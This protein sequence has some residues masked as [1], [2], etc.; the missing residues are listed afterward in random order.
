MDSQFDCASI[1]FYLFRNC[2]ECLLKTCLKPTGTLTA[3]RLIIIL[4]W[5]IVARTVV[6][7]AVYCT[8]YTV[9][10][11][12]QYN[13]HNMLFTVTYGD[14]GTISSPIFYFRSTTYFLPKTFLS[15]AMTRKQGDKYNTQPKSRIQN[16]FWT[17]R[18]SIFWK[19]GYSWYVEGEVRVLWQQA[20]IFLVWVSDKGSDS[21][22][23]GWDSGI[24]L[25][26]CQQEIGKETGTVGVT[27][28][29]QFCLGDVWYP[30]T[31]LNLQVY[32]L[33]TVLCNTQ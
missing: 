4:I 16:L 30:I 28:N 5:S 7:R 9:H 23:W 29:R 2:C 14:Y 3:K 26:W 20:R 18:K 21:T 8:L 31:V 10:T 17:K 24:P 1:L 6:V 19:W 22:I 12:I 25:F 11:Y 27:Y 13:F 32:L 15:W 33:Y